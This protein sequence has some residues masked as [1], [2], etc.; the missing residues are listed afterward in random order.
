[1]NMTAQ[2]LNPEVLGSLLDRLGHEAGRFRFEVAPNPCVGAA[3]LAAGEVVGMGYHETYGGPHAEIQA[4]AVARASG[5]PQADWDTIAVTLEPCSTTGKTPPCVK[6]ILDS[7]IQNVVVS[8][9]DPNPS[10]EGRGLR[11][12][13]DAGL[14]VRVMDGI[15]R[16][17]D[18][19]PH[20]LRWVANER[21]RR[22]RPWMI[23]KWAQTMTGQM[24]PPADVGEGR[25]ISGQESLMEVQLLRA[26]VDALVTGVG[27]VLA[28]NPRLS[29]R[30]PGRTE[31]P[32][33]RIILDSWLRTPTDARLFEEPAEGE[34]AG[35][36]IIMCLPGSN[37]VRWRALEQAGARIVEI[38]GEDR[39]RLRLLDV[40]SWLAREGHSRVLLETGPTL[41]RRYLESGFVDQV[42]MITGNVRGGEGPS[43]ADWIQEAKLKQPMMRESGSDSVMEAFL[44]LEF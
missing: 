12:L 18:V 1:M 36:V 39:K 35:P 26:K 16:L 41:L 19:S 15:C 42:R 17:E 14:T 23:A 29:V 5:V 11:M 22:P 4:L 3:V 2:T 13:E 21:V 10:H 27:T 24:T 9:L 44:G 28:D 20:F 6:A 43:L 34:S 33:A 32:P 7:G 31:H 37:A 25:W 38:R 40:Q 30:P 8:Q